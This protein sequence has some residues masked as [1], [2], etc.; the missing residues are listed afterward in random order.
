MGGDKA[1]AG[2]DVNEHRGRGNSSSISWMIASVLVGA[3]GALVN[4]GVLHIWDGQGSTAAIRVGL[5]FLTPGVGLLVLL[6][7]QLVDL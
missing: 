6:I 3:G 7:S 1:D 2:N 4:L 5:S